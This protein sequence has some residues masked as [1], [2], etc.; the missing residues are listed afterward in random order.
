MKIE[1]LVRKNRE[2]YKHNYHPFKS[3]RKV[4]YNLYEL[5]GW[6][7]WKKAILYLDFASMKSYLRIRRELT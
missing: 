3:R 7:F 2:N 6:R 5:S 1:N 4:F